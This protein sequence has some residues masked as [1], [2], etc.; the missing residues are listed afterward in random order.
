LHTCIITTEIT[1]QNTSAG[2][3]LRSTVIAKGTHGWT[4]QD[5]LRQLPAIMRDK[6]RPWE[7]QPL[8]N[9]ELKNH[10]NFPST[11]YQIR[12]LLLC[13]Q[14]VSPRFVTFSYKTDL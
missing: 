11:L 3:A 14:L 1:E 2:F 9:G 13:G 12:N 10:F 5:K 6:L 4:S 7:A 8:W